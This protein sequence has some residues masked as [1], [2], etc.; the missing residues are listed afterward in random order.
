MSGNY[1]VDVSFG[2]NNSKT[3]QN[4]MALTGDGAVK[5]LFYE[6]GTVDVASLADGVGATS[7]LTVN[8]VAL[9][10]IVL[11]VSMG[12]DAA[13][14]TVTGYVSAANIVSVRFQNESGG[15]VNLASTTMRV[16]VA[17]LT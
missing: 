2:N 16:L 7:T 9:G 12:V 4:L 3:W 6:S 13:G 5:G 17:D 14:M 11:G 8:G 1:K 15:G 10:D